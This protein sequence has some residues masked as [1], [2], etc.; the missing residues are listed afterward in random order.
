[1]AAYAQNITTA[2]TQYKC[3]TDCAAAIGNISSATQMITK[4]I[5]SINSYSSEVIANS[6]LDI[7][8]KVSGAIG[9]MPDAPAP[10]EPQQPPQ[11]ITPMQTQEPE[12]P[13]TPPAE[14][15]PQ[16]Q[17]PQTDQNNGAQQ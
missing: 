6:V 14:N 13:Q 15:Q 2:Q 5:V 8:S 10:Q 11:K 4:S 17:Q 1:M 16:D 7:L 9:S 12:Q 3:N